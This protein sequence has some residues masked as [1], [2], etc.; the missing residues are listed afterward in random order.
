MRGTQQKWDHIVAR[1]LDRPRDV[2]SFI[3]II[4]E[5]KVD[6]DL[7]SNDEISGARAEYSTYFKEELDDEIKAH[8][9]GWEEALAA[10]R[11]I[12]YV[13]F[14]KSQFEEA[15]DRLE[16]VWKRLCTVGRM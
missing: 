9:S 2:I 11:D 5:Q 6:A 10:L 7:L 1:T 3:N 12:G 8:W 16:T 13:T 14:V 15:Y 4:L